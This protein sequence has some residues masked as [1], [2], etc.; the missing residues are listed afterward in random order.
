MP[1]KTATGAAAVKRV[2]YLEPTTAIQEERQRRVLDAIGVKRKYPSLSLSAA[3]KR[4][5]TTVKTIRR[6]APSVVEIRSGRLD[7]KPTDR[8]PRRMK[9]L[10]AN[11]LDTV[12]VRNSRDATRISNFDNAIRQARRTFGVETAKLERFTNKSLRAGGKTYE[13]LTDYRTIEQLARAGEVHFLDIYAVGP[14]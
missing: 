2:A 9:L 13:F 6:Y 1:K 7:V 4:V 8:I 12:L 10:T 5:G 3:A 14:Q 11:G